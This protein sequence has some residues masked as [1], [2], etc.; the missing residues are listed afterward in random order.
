VERKLDELEG[1]LQVSPN[2]PS[3]QPLRR[4][5]QYL[6]LSTLLR[7]HRLVHV[8]WR[9]QN[10]VESNPRPLTERH[11]VSGGWDRWNLSL[12]LSLSLCVCVCMCVSLSH[13]CWT[14]WMVQISP[15]ESQVAASAPPRVF[16]PS[17]GVSTDTLVSTRLL[18]FTPCVI[19]ALN[20]LRCRGREVVPCLLNRHCKCGLAFSPG[21]RGHM[22]VES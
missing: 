14:V 5:L 13:H 17:P 6:L 15:V 9:N 1:A 2:F 8:T 22:P 10:L 11:D 12:S 21:Q 4:E 20:K 19:V 7:R 16:I 18:P 3:N